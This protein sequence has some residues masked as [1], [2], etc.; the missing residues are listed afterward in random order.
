MPESLNFKS[1]FLQRSIRGDFHSDAL[2][3]IQFHAESSDQLL[4]DFATERRGYLPVKKHAFLPAGSKSP[5]ISF[6]REVATSNISEILPMAKRVKFGS[7]N[8][9][10]RFAESALKFKNDLEKLDLLDR[11]V[12][13]RVPFVDKSN[14]DLSVPLVH[15][16]P[17][18]I[19]NELFIPYYD[20]LEGLGFKVTKALPSEF[21]IADS[22]HEWGIGPDHFIPEAYEWWAEAL[23]NLGK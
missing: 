20:Y 19:W 7:R 14:S 6:T 4:I 13:V 11:T 22:N 8:H 10:S 2:K 9:F 5:V 21:A 12:I 3:R 18:K 1:K 17:G 15:Q 16:V 23:D